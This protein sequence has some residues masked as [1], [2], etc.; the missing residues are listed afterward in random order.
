MYCEHLI[1][2]FILYTMQ[3]TQVK[4]FIFELNADE[5]NTL[6]NELDNLNEMYWND[7]LVDLYSN[8]V[9][10]LPEIYTQISIDEAY[11][12]YNAFS[13]IP[14]NERQPMMHQIYNAVGN[15]LQVGVKAS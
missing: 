5:V 13:A 7:N 1:Q 15:A 12:L 2:L 10:F 14:Y 8:V 4:N 9:S 11:E 3:F 6:R